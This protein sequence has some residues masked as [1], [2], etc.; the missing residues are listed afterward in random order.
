LLA[1]LSV[2]TV[3]GRWTHPFHAYGRKQWRVLRGK[4][5]RG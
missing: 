5:E 4:L 3:G 1:A 2:G